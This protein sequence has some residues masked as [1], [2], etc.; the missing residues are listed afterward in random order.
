MTME[1][2][3]S[4]VRV[5]GL[6]HYVAGPY[7]TLLLASLGA[8]VI[9][10]EKPGEGD[11]ARKLGPFPQGI[12]HPEKSGTFLY[13]NMSK[14]GI[15]LN[16]KTSDGQH[17][18]RKLVSQA[19]VVVENF[20]PRVMANLGLDYECLASIN[21]KLVLTSI[22]NF[23]QSGPYRDYKA[24][25]LIAQ[26][27]SGVLYIT[28]FYD[29]EPLK[30][31]LSQAQLT[32]GLVAA[33]ATLGAVYAANKSGQGDHVDI[34]LMESMMLALAF[35]PL[36]QYLYSGGVFRRKPKQNTGDLS[37]LLYELED[38]YGLVHF[39]GPPDW[40]TFARILGSPEL[41]NEKF[42]DFR[43][44]TMHMEEIDSWLRPLLKKWRK[45][46]F[47]GTFR[48]LGYPYGIVQNLDDIMRCPQLN[49]RGFFRDINH[50][51]AG[52]LR[53]PG[54]PFKMSETPYQLARAPLLGEHNEEVYCRRLGY[55]NEDLVRMRQAGII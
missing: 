48:E 24:T 51:E 26:A 7:C 20:E 17:I 32:G 21:P 43:G 42:A 28:G 37:Q 36:P 19:D 55:S 52:M 2:A 23:G 6:T 38:G 50:P 9:K 12:A 33:G 13:L 18:F 34:S 8:E 30:V 54:M 40:M 1:Q 4:H 16:L 44:R 35:N 14:K 53:Y 41:E 29:R 49:E 25:E 46:E 39:I 31:P 3:L 11:G 5:L 10:I 45:E 27:M 22:S 47:L 15:T